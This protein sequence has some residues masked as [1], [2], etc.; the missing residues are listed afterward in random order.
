M[1]LMMSS[2]ICNIVAQSNAFTAACF[3]PLYSRYSISLL[4]FFLPLAVFF[5]CFSF[6][7]RDCNGYDFSFLPTITYAW[8]RIYE[9]KR[10]YPSSVASKISTGR[11][12]NLPSSDREREREI[13]REERG[14]EEREKMVRTDKRSCRLF[15]IV[16][17]HLPESDDELRTC[18]RKCMKVQRRQMKVKSPYP[19]KIYAC[20]YYW[21]R[22][23][24]HHGDHLF[25]ISNN[26][27]YN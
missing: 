14:E 5:S 8:K 9:I 23:N 11:W 24:V 12:R 3:S 25:I 19:T 4:F 21:I 16:S 18:H 26:Y 6:S 1:G 20:V 27:T 22:N 15:W 10:E 7:A 13:E 2:R 17:Q